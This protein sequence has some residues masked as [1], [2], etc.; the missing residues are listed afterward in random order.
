MSTIQNKSLWDLIQEKIVLGNE[1]ARGWYAVK[2]ACCNDYQERGGFIHDD[3]YTSYSCWNCGSKFKYEEGSGKF[4]RNLRDI[5]EAFGISREDLRAISASLF[6]NKSAEKEE[7]EISLKEVSRLKL[8]TPEVAFPDRTLAL[9]CDGHDE[10]QAPLIEYLNSRFIDPIKHQIHF[11]LDPRYLR[12][13]IIPF[14]RDGKLI[15]W[16]A[17]TIDNIKPRYLNCVVA[18]DAVLYGYDEL[19]RYSAKPLFITEGVFDAMS[20]DGVCLLGSA[21]NAAKIEILK[22]TKRRIIFVIDRDRTGDVLAKT[23]IEN[24]W[25]FTFVDKNADDVNDSVRKF[26]LPYTAY[27]L[28]KNAFKDDPQSQFNKAKAANHLGIEMLE[29]RLRSR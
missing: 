15:Y 16:Q 3:I 4:S 1:N 20:V 29:A 22:R 25:E 18:K 11:S 7:A 17:R 14:M 27:C 8:V 28:M 21:L 12:R 19:T 5:L 23:V 6:F 2:C 10:I 9:G 26:G 13:V 24:D